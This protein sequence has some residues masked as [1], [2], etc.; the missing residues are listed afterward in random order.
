MR[1]GAVVVIGYRC[2][3]AAA[4]QGRR[5]TMEDRSV[6]MDSVAVG[7]GVGS[8]ALWWGEGAPAAAPHRSRI[9]RT[10]PPPCRCIFD[11]HGGD[12]ASKFAANRLPAVLFDALSAGADPS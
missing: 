9:T 10:R 11:G 2:L 6:T 8:V 5:P 7:G 12:S 1:A 3:R 4:R